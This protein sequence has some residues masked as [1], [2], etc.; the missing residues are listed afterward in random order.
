MELPEI[1]QRLGTALGLGLIVGL[2]RERAGAVLAGIRTF[3][4]IT[5]FGTLCAMLGNWPI[6]AGLLA[7]GAIIVGGGINQP[8]EKNPGL[9]TEISML[10]M[11]GIGAALAEGPVAPAIAVAGAVSVLL[12]L[13]PQMHGFV[14]KLGDQDFKAIMQFV[15]VSL[16]ILPSLPNRAFGPYNVLNP[17]KLWLTVVLIVGIS[18]VGFLI[19]RFFGQKAGVAAAGFLGGLISSTATTVSY[20]RRTKGETAASTMAAVIIMI[21]S[22]VV[23]ARVI[24]IIGVTSPDF[25]PKASLPLAVMLVGCSAIAFVLARRKDST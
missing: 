13:K 18:L 10:V 14:A 20:A 4:L 23:F 12:H 2:Q 16:V 17:Y 19:Y 21:A 6:A 7:L 15:V 3:P 24:A 22:T 5:I 8:D 9:T 11:F 25:L 1:F